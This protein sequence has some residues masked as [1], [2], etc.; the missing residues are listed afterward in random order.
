[1]TEQHEERLAIRTGM[2]A[3]PL[4][5]RRL[6][7]A[8]GKRLIVVTADAGFGKTS[9]LRM[10]AADLEHAWYTLT[11][12]DR[13]L[14][15]LVRGVAASVLQALPHLGALSAGATAEPVDAEAEAAWI[16]R[17]LA[18]DV[19]HDFMLVLD[20][21]HELGAD[22]DAAYFVESL[23]RQASP[24]VHVVLASRAEPPFRIERL[25]GRGEVLEL[26]A[27]VLA[28]DT[29]EVSTLVHAVTG[30]DEME[31]VA[32]LVAAT[33]G[34]PAAV[35]LALDSLENEA[36]PA[37]RTAMF[38]KAFRPGGDVYAY[39]AGEALAD[40][41]EPVRELLRRLSPFDRISV[42]LCTALG[43]PDT[44]EAMA[45]LLKRGLVAELPDGGQMIHALVREFARL[46]WPLEADEA[47]RVHRT[48]AV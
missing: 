9:L 18:T 19:A 2:L 43:V 20:D 44:E 21:V 22:T 5:A 8:F 32:D 36:D 15:T 41:T 30:A 4:L 11:A 35:R 48:A 27:R 12:A 33:G 42:E 14:E 39:L 17:T 31:L 47:R 38:T 25:R 23:C 1:M 40:A 6:D 37:R 13:E 7:G 10:W 46:T 29:E 3:R 16:C 34:W 28:F 45:A 24:N 26:N